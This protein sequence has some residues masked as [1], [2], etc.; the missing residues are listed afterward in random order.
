M[1]FTKQKQKQKKEKIQYKNIE[2]IIEP[3]TDENEKDYV[4]V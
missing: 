2:I 1:C 4:F 3:S